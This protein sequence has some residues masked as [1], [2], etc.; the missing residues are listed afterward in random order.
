[1]NIIKTLI[2]EG[3]SMKIAAIFARMNSMVMFYHYI[4]NPIGYKWIKSIQKRQ[5]HSKELRLKASSAL[6]PKEYIRLMNESHDILCEIEKEVFG[7]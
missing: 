7:T 1:M 4:F 2:A 6:T 5:N 3:A